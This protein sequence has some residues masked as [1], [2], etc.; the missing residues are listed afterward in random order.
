MRRRAPGYALGLVLLVGV[1]LP[2]AADDAPAAPA[3]AAP[4]TPTEPA[5]T[6]PAAPAVTVPTYPNTTCPIMG[7][8]ASKAMFADT[9]HGRIY[10]C[11]PPCIAKILKDPE[12]AYAAAYPVAKKAG[13]SVC[14][15]TDKALAADAVTVVLQGYEVG[16]CATCAK[17]AQENSQIVLAKALDSK[18][19]EIRN[20][21]C[22]ITNQPVATNAFCVIGNELVHLSDPKAVEEV[23]K[24]PVKALQAAKDI[25]ARQDAA[26]AAAAPAPGQPVR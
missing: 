26:A 21:T 24:D 20:R 22:P 3:P 10:V 17:Q 5:P 16:V 1:S 25:V 11:C 6:E 12:R 9:I 2:A 18:I 7:K 23:K 4:A 8:A 19:V 15:I 13:N 14:P